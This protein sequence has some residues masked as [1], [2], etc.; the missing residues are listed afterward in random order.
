MQTLRQNGWQRVL[1]GDTSLDELIRVCP[2]ET[3]NP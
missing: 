2:L 1:A 3:E